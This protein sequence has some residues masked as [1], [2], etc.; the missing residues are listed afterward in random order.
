MTAQ[1]STRN[2]ADLRAELL[3][4]RLAGQS[5]AAR[6]D[7]I[8]RAD[9]DGVLPLSHGQQQMWF[10]SR[11]DPNSIEYLVP[12]MMRL[13]G[14]LDV[15]VLRRAWE[16]VCA[17]H[18]VLRTRIEL[19][20][21]E[22]VQ[23]IDAPRPVALPE[24]DLTGRPET[25]VEAFLR[26]DLQAPFDLAADWPVRGALLRLG[27]DHHVLAVV[28]HH[29]ACDAWSTRMFGSELSVAYNA[30]S[31]G[32]APALPELPVQYA[33]FA[34]WQGRELA[35]DRGERE[36]SY[37]RERLAG[38]EPI[39]LPTDRP[40]PPVRGHDGA[41]VVFDVPAELADL[42]RARAREFDTT[43]F[44]VLLSAYQ[45]MLSRFS[46]TDDVAVGTVVSGRAHADLQRVFGY[47]INTLVMRA[48]CDGSFAELLRRGRATVLDGFDH[49][50]VP[51][52]RLVDELQ[53]DRDQSR[54]PI[55]QT[56][57]TLHEYRLDVLQFAGLTAEPFGD[58][59]G[60]AKYDL[61]LQMQE[62]PDGTIHGR[63]QYATAL[64]D[65]A[66]ASR[67]A[68]AF[69]RVLAAAVTDP[70]IRLSDIEILSP[71]ERAAVVVPPVEGPAVV[72]TA[73]EFFEARAAENPD[74][75]AVV[76]GETRLTYA[77]VNARANRLAWLLRDA[78]VGPE[79][80]VGVHLERGADLIP[81][82]L[83]VLKSGAGYLPLD[84]A[85]PMER[86]GYV[87]QDAGARIVVTSPE[88]APGLSEVFDGRLIT[89][90]EDGWTNN[91]PRSATPENVIYTIYTS[92]STGRPKG[93]MLT[94]ANV[95]R[96][97][98]VCRT[99]LGIRSDDVWSLVHSFA[100]DF[101]V[102]EMWGA[103]MYGGTVVVVPRS[104]ARSPEDFFQLLVDE[105][106]T[107]LSQTPTAFRSLTAVADGRFD[108]LSIRSVVFGGE[109]LEIAEIQPWAGKV[110]LVN[111]YGITE[112]T[113]HVTVH[114]LTEQDLINPSV[115]P[116]GVA[117]PDLAVYLLDQAGQPV[118]I[119]VPGEIYV[120]G[121]GVARGYL[122][123]APLTA[124][125]FVPDPFGEPGTRMYRSGDLARWTTEGTLE[126]LGR[127]DDQV[128][129]RG[130][131]IELGEVSAA[132]SACD[133]VREAVTVLA[134]DRLVGY[135]VTE[136]DLDRAAV[137]EEL[138]RTLP[139]YMVPAALVE[140]ETIP[141]TANG[142]LDKRALPAPDAAQL[143]S[144]GEYVAP[145]TPAE[146]AVAAVWRA[147]LGADRVGVTD[148][149]FELGGD[150]M[151]AV[152]LVGALREAG[153]Q[154]SVRDVF[155][156]R[157]VARLV[158]F[159]GE[160]SA[161]AAY[162]P[163]RPFELIDEADRALLP[164]GIVDAYPLGQNQLGMVIEMLADDGQNN[165][166]N[167]S[168][169]WI[170][171]D[172]PFLPG[173]FAEAGRIVLA[174]H[175]V[176]RTSIELTA[177]SRPMQLV[178]AHAEMTTDV[179]DCS[180]MT[181]EQVRTEVQEFG[182]RERA[183]PFDMSVP[184]LMRFH[185]H[186]TTGLGGWWL[187]LVECHPILEGWSYHSLLMEFVTTYLT[188]RAGNTPEEVQ[189]PPIRFA[190]AIAGELAALES[191]DDRAYWRDLVRSHAPLSLPAGWGDSEAPAAAPYKTG[192][193]W[194]DLESGL[195]ALAAATDTSM[196][197]VMLAA[198]LKVMSQLTEEE[199]FHSGLVCDVRPEV[200]G[201]D[202]VYG[203][204]L[205]TLPFPYARGARTWGDLV[206]DVFAAEVDLWGHRRFPL[207]AV[208]REW[209]GSG[210]IMD[211]YFN[212]QDFRQLDT[213]V[214]D[215]ASGMDDSPTEFPL[216]VASRA[217]Y[218][219]L[220]ANRRHLTTAAADN[221][222]AMYR[223]VLQSMAADG[224]R[225]DALAVYLSP[226]ERAALVAPP[227]VRPGTDVLAHELFEARVAERPD[228]IAVVA[229]DV[230]LTYAEV[231]ARANRLAWL[232]RDAGVGPE[233][234]VG[235]HLERGVDLVP[236]LLG[237]LKSGAGYLPLD[238]ANPLERLGYVL[239]DAGAEIVITSPELA[240][241]LADVFDGK[242]ILVSE[243]TEGRTDNPSRVS[244]PDGVIY[245]IYTS[246]STGRPKGV[247]LSHR[248]V[249]RLLDT[250]QEHY[251]FD[252]SDVWSLAHSYA[253]DVSVFE[254]WG[255]LAFGGRIVVVPRSVARSPEDFL[256]LLLN[257]RVTVLSQTPTA[258]RSIVTAAGEG[259]E[260][261]DRLD[262]RA[263]IFAGEKLEVAELQPWVDR[264]GLER[265]A[266]VNMYGITETTVH[267]TYHRLDELDI[268]DPGMN[269]VGDPLS[270][271]AVYLL[272]ATGHP[273][274]FGVTG[275][276]YVAGPGVARGYLG[277][278]SL[279]AQRFVP[280]PFG[281]AGSRMYRSGDLARRR[282][283]GTLEFLGRA[284]DQVKIRGFR[285]ELGEI[286]A[287][288]SACDGV[289]E[290]V[291]V[292]VD[293]RLVGYLVGHAP[294]P[295][296]IR[297]TLARTL[298]EYMVPAAFVEIDAIPLTNNGKLDR[299]ALPAPGEQ[300]Y[301]NDRYVAPRT[302]GE[303]RMAAIWAHALKL[304]R[305]GVEDDFFELGGDSIRAVSLVG[306]LQAAGF[307]VG[308]LDVFEHT[309]VAAL[310]ASATGNTVQ[311]TPV[312][313]VAPFE[314][315]SDDD[316]ARLPEGL[317][318]AY[319]LLRTQTGMLV[320]TL[321]S[322]AQA[323]YHDFTS[324]LVRDGAPF[325][326][327]LFREAVT[328]VARRHDILRTSVDL[329]GYSVPMQLVHHD[330][331]IPVACH[332]LRDIDPAELRGTLEAF[333]AAERGA[334]FDLSTPLPLLR[335]NVHVQ[336]GDSWRL[337]FTKSHALLEGWSYHQLLKELVEALRGLRDGTEA[338]YEAPP[339]RFADTVAAELTSLASDAD[340]EFWNGL[341]GEYEPLTLPR[342]WHGDLTVPAERIDGGFSFADLEP[343]L[344]ELAATA[345]VPFKAVLLGAHLKVLS[346]LTGAERFFTGLVGHVRPEVQGSERLIG[347]YITTLPH[348]F[349]RDAAT[350]GDLV[351]RVFDDEAAAWPHRSYP[352]PAIASAGQRL[353]DT[354]F[355]YLDFHLLDDGDV[356]DEGNGINRT[357]M[358]FGLA[359][360]A[361]GGVLGLR[362]NT[363]LLSRENIDR[364]AGMYRA[365]LAGMAADGTGG[366]ARA[367]YLPPAER[368]A[369]VVPPVAGPSAD[370]LAHEFFEAR[371]A[372]NPDALAVVAGETRLTYAE[373]NA[374]AN[375]LAWLLRD[376]GVGP[377]DLV[378]VHLE[379]GPDLMPALLGVLKSG[380]GYL[381][382]DP[383]NPMERLG[384]VVEDAGAEIVVTTP[385]LAPGLSEVF[386]GKL[387]VLP[388][389]GREDNPPTV[390][391]P[392][393]VI[394]TIYTSGSTG[395]PKG[396]MLTHA[397]VVRLMEVCR[398]E[399]GIR[400]D[401]VWSLV[402]SFAFD[403]S[404]FEMWG[405]LM[406]G[407]TVVVVPRSVA[408][409]PEDFFQLLVDEKVT[410]LSQTPTAF[411]SLT[412]FAGDERLSLKSVVFGGE[413]LEIAEIQ[414]WA[415]KV[416]LVNM[417]GITETTVHVTV[418]ELTAQD[419]VNTSV[420]PAGVALPDLSVYLL[421]QAGQPVPVGVP[422]EIY[423]A[424][425][426]VARGYLGRA[427]LTAQRF[428][429]D[430]FGQPGT[431]MYRS[432]DLARWTTEGTLE[433]LG[434]ADD[435][436][437]IRG[438]RI[439][440]GE[441]SAA[442]SACDG[443]REAVTVLVDG[444]L[445]GYLV[446]AGR[447][448]TRAIRETIVRTLPDYMV[449]AALVE[450]DAIP[451]TTNGKLDKRALPAPDGGQL[452]AATG[453]TP[454]TP[455]EQQLA[456][457]WAQVLDLP[458][459]GV[460]DSFF[461][462]G[463]D[464]IRAVSLV[465]A[466]R[467]AG[468]DISVTDVFERR[469][470]AALAEL[471]GSRTAPAEPHRATAPFALISEADRRL[472]PDGVV[473]AYPMLQAQAGMLFELEAGEVAH[474]HSTGGYKVIDDAP[475]DVDALRAAVRAVCARHEALRTSFDLSTYSIPLQ[476]VHERAEPPVG[477][478]DLRGLDDAARDA[479]LDDYVTGEQS[480]PIDP[481]AVPQLR[482]GALVADD[483]WWLALSR[484]HM[485]T[486]GW[487]QHEMLMEL[488]DCYR[489]LRDG[490]TPAR[491]DTL[492]VRFADT[493]AAE[494][495]A[496]ESPAHREFWQGVVDD[497]M[498]FRLPAWGDA[499]GPDEAY[500]ITVPAMDLEGPL[501]GLAMS[502]RTSVKSVLLAAHLKVLSQLTNEPAF[503]AGLVCDTRLE[504][505]GAD[506]VHG[507]F[508]NTLPFPYDRSAATWRE[509]VRAVFDAE[510]A[511]WP[512]R[513]YPMAGVSRLAGGTGRLVDVIFNYQ[514]FHNLDGGR[515][516]LAA[517]F[518]TGTNEFG[519]T[520][521]TSNGG[522]TLKT[523]TSV[524]SREHVSR[525]ASMY[526][527]VLE[528]MAADPEGDAGRVFLP[529]DD[530]ARIS[531]WEP[532]AEGTVTDRP[533]P[534]SFAEQAAR[535]P[536]ALAVRG[537]GFE[538]TFAEL[539]GRAG[540]VA[541]ALRNAGV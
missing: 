64:F 332:D 44:T 188:L 259:D 87:V 283:D 371:V 262:L 240:P 541:T 121:P 525:L 198:H 312:L 290:A 533:V 296:A 27:E 396:C 434:R 397:N 261:I 409:S 155:E 10:L 212:Y 464:S 104:V 316:R 403:F 17:R 52:A 72:K 537:N 306:A 213:E 35:G 365:V 263:V 152:A 324:F 99:E 329:T 192:F 219:I 37:W 282:A 318:D 292:L 246:G 449:P 54:T 436:V 474:Y 367:T 379:R 13:R 191:E 115:S 410:F 466:V 295:R 106:V 442:L 348:P 540:A 30:L 113:V 492:G 69:Q 255:A 323:N 272:D 368:A 388:S 281:P 280:D 480:R 11:L 80:L 100:F 8:P 268:A 467:A 159:A 458:Q 276:I 303:Q 334:P 116:A 375:R 111:M 132:L 102:F 197:A 277:R 57:F 386:N 435:Q 114:E 247:V 223:A 515:I 491:P 41:D 225:G 208:L 490:A 29:V 373:V 204:F 516:D 539:L 142:K 382:L 89:L 1:Q 502:S 108:E 175:D 307:A 149:F 457:V 463:G 300:T 51:F 267:T 357:A 82:L 32:E 185:A 215:A 489:A 460:E 294:D 90:P 252:S 358:E 19:R 248:N 269:R 81:T 270:D 447:L 85:N 187:S 344:R 126:F 359:V 164:G 301:D 284:D 21:V 260:R 509:L 401:D 517:G 424:G 482:I 271:L 328:L 224:A 415:G 2:V 172:Q 416:A 352:M 55:F 345:G 228:A 70:E 361:I 168:A 432:G 178:H 481:A 499:T 479:A 24:I 7:T 15:D 381:P 239:E 203:M 161:D 216:T 500:Q 103:L 514:D 521:T 360:T 322:G 190:D 462:L 58:D 196:K 369:V 245:T 193:S 45:A 470:V 98:E 144:A 417:Y 227:A 325:D 180:G 529:A 428:V 362:S 451:L 123:R 333:A 153:Y 340:R 250:A 96:L 14:P 166:H 101:S 25:E 131:R 47:C 6:R 243:K 486:E 231:N 78:G 522:L 63:L 195:R 536:R 305:V 532:A 26:R 74:A 3:R 84:P 169:Y 364:I 241:G 448:D 122:G 125:R 346:Q 302:P 384:Y 405:A 141:L 455:L 264:V 343:G 308:V 249:T 338:G 275:E 194:R 4:K 377:E 504:V 211:V 429:P 33:D 524:L 205:N 170:H 184:G 95:V 512:H 177:Y 127:A 86:L 266:L 527:Q 450:I 399:L 461:D 265:V 71:A 5:G 443:V 423:V 199:S 139:D 519:L 372:E 408:R 309:T 420:S 50:A 79:D 158:E 218:L 232:L 356:V 130:F 56:A 501:R 65:P 453:V 445:V 390:A 182:V 419:L 186:T 473:D 145:R 210:R 150:S 217:G 354:F 34:Q 427:A 530:T 437:K 287:A 444:R 385:E 234:L 38:L 138:A 404:V 36:L 452:P 226:A 508:L 22:P 341:V 128:K 171:D 456:L 110:A 411:R 157:T 119:G 163:V 148:S 342:D 317:D 475:F 440:L 497:R 93:C 31:R 520:V 48:D 511:M 330:V 298:P 18:E 162:R 439:E 478:V 503:H 207:P 363:H 97:M 136:G 313:A 414:P 311:P 528:A 291:T 285:I 73:H 351:R 238:P 137:R 59:D 230:E 468:H 407:G 471:I 117:L 321:A 68:G 201:A 465:G 167:V 176:L 485:I 523:R 493:V 441:V 60:I 134:G 495:A 535:T 459:A 335:I 327:G 507:M 236:T 299:R 392:E 339:V 273:V 233:D 288:L 140:I 350:W 76:A 418:H 391:T 135:L 310:C 320:E 49:H 431:R 425:P 505:L 398:T 518:G 43:A 143:R 39:S 484:S 124:Q 109:K 120:A 297:E 133:G 421:D 107:V 336:T 12:L 173:A 61:T 75:L 289:R 534:L 370:R 376:A 23:V 483:G 105:K 513:R 526:R 257:Q 319:P 220:T 244:T 274:P 237:V 183:N 40:R 510:V 179:W 229:G 389:T 454:R 446:P 477:V 347:M 413:K 469:T 326:A 77:E 304:E 221:L 151:R 314:L 66:T 28:F 53:P 393:N 94:H 9:R 202:R 118:P 395:R 129:I 181:A 387:I 67:L 160:T 91:P 146:E 112:T 154:V 538:V 337:S 355:S 147:V 278:P 380:A 331:T 402:H 88:L 349:A 293:G 506:R 42:V 235:V 406:Y 16:H 438:F 494:L 412:P 472:V 279:T 242:L 496:L 222:A 374:R 315:I 20:G 286:S 251:S 383:A 254:M 200:T 189:A 206:R 209:P 498:P 487:S 165:Y 394:Y 174:R 400:S 430:P 92:G 378:G 62:R 353:I 83:G 531:A 46:G 256:D 488:V 366:D 426:G 433:F 253:F 156:H 258:F 214:V 422:G 476:L